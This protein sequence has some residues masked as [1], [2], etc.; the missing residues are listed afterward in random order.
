MCCENVNVYN[1]DIYIDMYVLEVYV[2]KLL[3]MRF[4][5][6]NFEFKVYVLVLVVIVVVVTNVQYCCCWLCVIATTLFRLCCTF[7]RSRARLH[8]TSHLFFVW[9]SRI[10]FRSQLLYTL[11][12]YLIDFFFSSYFVV[13]IFFGH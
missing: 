9:L 4:I 8:Y 12:F 2:H 6:F 11:Y 7:S 5:E 3:V 13:Y 10:V 1:M